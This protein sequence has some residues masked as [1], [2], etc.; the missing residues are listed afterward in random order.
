MY[1][2]WLLL[3]GR[4]EQLQQRPH[5]LAAPNIYYLAL[6]SVSLA[7]LNDLRCQQQSRKTKT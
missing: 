1:A 2:L 4:G 5:S 6:H 7:T 3:E